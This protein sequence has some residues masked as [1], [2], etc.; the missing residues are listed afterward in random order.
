[1]RFIDRC[2]NPSRAYRVRPAASVFPQAFRRV[3]GK[4]LLE[5]SRQSHG[6][7]ML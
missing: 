6:K 3:A 4:K 7:T 5:F 1:L 2:E